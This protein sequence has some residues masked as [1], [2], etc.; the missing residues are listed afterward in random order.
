[1]RMLDNFTRFSRIELA[2]SAQLESRETGQIPFKLE[3]IW[4]TD[5]FNLLLKTPFGGDLAE[6]RCK[7]EGA[8]SNQLLGIEAGNRLGSN[9]SRALKRVKDPTLRS[10]LDRGLS[11]LKGTNDK[12]DG[13][14]AIEL[15]DDRLIP[16]MSLIDMGRFSEFLH[17]SPC[18]RNV[19]GGWFWGALIPGK[20]AVFKYENGIDDP[21]S[22]FA[23]GDT[24]WV[25]DNVSG[26][27]KEMRTPGLIVKALDIEKK[28]KCWLPRKIKIIETD[29]ARQLILNRRRLNLEYSE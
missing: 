27:C 16:L 7:P 13:G 18:C 22:S 6:I 21:V 14:F 12:L 23:S 1:L 28:K 20:D 29:S 25:I 11:A 15:S 19:I 10:L 24:I 4:S 17:E 2:Y 8:S 3:L 5:D 9:I 26:I